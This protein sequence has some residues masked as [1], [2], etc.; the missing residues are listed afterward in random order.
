METRQHSLSLKVI[1]WVTQIS[2]WLF[3][4]VGLLMVGIA[5]GLLFNLFNS[6]LNLH[7]GLPVAF[8]LTETGKLQLLNKSIPVTFEEAY[9]KIGFSELPAVASR[10]YGIFILLVIGIFFY[11]FKTFRRFIINV[12][13]GLVFEMDNFKLLRNMA[14]GLLIFWIFI[15]IYSVLQNFMI[16]QHLNFESLEY[17]GSMQFHFEVVFVALILLVLSHIFMYGAKLKEDN[18]LTI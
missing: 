6:D 18:E 8:D 13:K 2:F 15:V 10:I 1:Y 14:Y 9:G 11:I 7:V 3:A 5:F 17:A 12:Y 4:A 16:A